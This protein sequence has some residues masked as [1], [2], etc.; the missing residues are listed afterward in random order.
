MPSKI[1]EAEWAAAKPDIKYLY[2]TLNK[3]LKDVRTEM[4]RRDFEAT[5][6]QYRTQFKKW[7]PKW[8][9]NSKVEDTEMLSIFI[10]QRKS[11][12]KESNVFEWGRLLGEEELRKRVARSTPSTL[13]RLEL[14]VAE[15]S[16]I[17]RRKDITKVTQKIT[18]FLAAVGTR[19]IQMVDLFIQ[20]GAIINPTI[21]GCI[22]RTPLQRAAEIGSFEMVELL[23]NFGADINALPAVSSGATAL[24]LAAIGGYNRIVCYLLNHKAKV[25]APAA[26]VRGMTALEGAAFNGRTDTVH[27]LLKA[28]AASHG[29]D[30]SQLDKAMKMAREEGHFPTADLIHDWPNLEDDGELRTL[31]DIEDDIGENEFDEFV[32]WDGE[33]YA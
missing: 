16:S 26:M 18:A 30:R 4:I 23:H 7:G 10:E 1:T 32:N 27:I 15:L 28:G 20:N 2:L 8:I 6:S 17:Q 3:S 29:K 33:C 19:N 31:D 24:Q 9:K 5:E 25:D 14:I 11:D 13:R 22:R 21:T 12:G